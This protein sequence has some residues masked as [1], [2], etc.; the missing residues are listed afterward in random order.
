M[1]LVSGNAGFVKWLRESSLFNFFWKSLRGISINSSLNVCKTSLRKLSGPVFFFVGRFLNID[2]IS[3]VVIGIFRFYISS[4]FSLAHC[5]LLWIFPFLL[6]CPV[7]G[8]IIVH[9][10]WSLNNAGVNGADLPHNWK[11]VYTIVNS[12]LTQ[13]PTLELTLEQCGFQLYRPIEVIHI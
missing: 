9:Y 7:C 10:S 5:M 4:W 6:G 3:L 11:S 8:C 2:L 13:I 12:P 1:A